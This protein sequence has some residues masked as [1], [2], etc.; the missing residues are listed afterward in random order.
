MNDYIQE[1][2]EKNKAEKKEEQLKNIQ[3]LANKLQIGSKEYPESSNYSRIDF[4]LWDQD[5]KKH[6]RYNIGKISD[7]EYVLLKDS[8]NDSVKETS[9][10]ID[11][12]AKS[13]WYIF[14]VIMAILGG[15]AVLITLIATISE[16]LEWA[17]F[18]IV[19]GSYL[20]FLSFLAIV[21]L[22]AD[23]KQGIDKLLALKN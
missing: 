3:K 16:E 20:L 8:I 4:P 6:Y 18:F 21:I 14:A 1:F 10:N 17:S 13:I 15:V 12:P 2:L 7:E 9:A 11:E 22:L 19:L 5:K 23:I